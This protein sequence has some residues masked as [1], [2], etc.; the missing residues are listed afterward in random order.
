MRTAWFGMASAGDWRPTK[1]SLRCSGRKCVSCHLRKTLA[2][3]SEIVD[4][5]HSKW[6]IHRICGISN[7]SMNR[8]NITDRSSSASKCLEKAWRMIRKIQPCLP[9]VVVVIMASGRRR[10]MGHF[11]GSVWRTTGIE[12]GHEVAVNPKLFDCP[13]DLLATL[14]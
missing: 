5:P 4:N 2:W 1:Y 11:C 6:L 7:I 13:E 3:L 14:L 12:S 9:T 8:N 10:K